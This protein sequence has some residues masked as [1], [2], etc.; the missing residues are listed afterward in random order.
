MADRQEAV[1]L[2][3]AEHVRDPYP[4][5]ARLREENPVCPMQRRRGRTS[6]LVTR[7]DD[8]V[9]AVLDPAL[10]NDPRS[11]STVTE[12]PRFP[13]GRHMVASDP[14]D[15]GRLR[16]L[17]AGALS[18]RRTGRL[19]P[20]IA[21]TA[22]DLLAALPT[23]EPVELAQDFA[24]PLAL[25][26]ISELLGVPHA[27][28]ADLSR[29]TLSILS[30]PADATAQFFADANAFHDYLNDLIETKRRNP[31]DAVISAMVAAHDH[32]GLVSAEELVSS[33]FQLVIAGYESSASTICTA[34]LALLEHPEELGYFRAARGR[35]LD[36]AVE[37]LLRHTS[38]LQVLAQRFVVAPLT[39]GPVTIPAGETVLLAVGSGNHDPRRFADPDRLDL[40]RENNQHFAFGYGRHLCLGATLGRLEIKIAMALLIGQFPALRL[41]IP[42][43]ELNWRPGLGFRALS[44][45]PIVLGPRHPGPRN[46]EIAS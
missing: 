33:V 29:W 20:H 8:I 45:L 37:E 3:T 17:V 40:R 32:E 12:G 16:R 11:V 43:N 26:V 44:T 30:S 27:D 15:H 18:P 39:I 13:M 7:Y 25:A 46:D 35:E 34:T 42:P 41:A 23:D 10:R 21:R 31:D 36:Q 19:A 24:F 1:D 5:F 22:N 38:T 9:R 28:R 6:W 14:P 2:T 4:L